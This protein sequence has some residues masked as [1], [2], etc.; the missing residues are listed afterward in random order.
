MNGIEYGYINTVNRENGT[1]TVMQPDKNRKI[2]GEIPFFSHCGE[3]K[4]PEIGA[5]VAVIWWG[6]SSCDGV[7]LGEWWSASNPPPAGA[8]YFKDM[9]GGASVQVKNGSLMLA[10]H[11]GTIAIGDLIKKLADYEAR[12]E[13]LEDRE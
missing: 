2:T 11:G 9:G 7:V 3:Y 4:V 12:I 10:D 6:S 1:V 13:R 5:M 8:E